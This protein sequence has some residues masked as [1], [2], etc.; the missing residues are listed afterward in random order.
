VAMQIRIGE[1][2]APHQGR[3]EYPAPVVLGM[4]LFI[5]SEIVFFG[6]L[7][8]AYYTLRG[9]ASVWPP[10]DALA[11]LAPQARLQAIAASL[12][13]WG[14]SVPVHL[15]VL[16]MR[17]RDGAAMRG[18]LLLTIGMG[19]VFMGW[20]VSEWASSPFSVSAHAYGTIFFALTG[21]HALH[22]LI[23]LILLS[24]VVARI[25]Q[26][27]YREGDQSGPEAV[28]YYWHFVDAVWVGVFATIYLV[29]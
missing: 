21:F 20:K 28:A 8:A 12:V 24:G 7:F 3:L 10:P 15:A 13:L 22:L 4:V 26:G 25:A 2:R 9:G 18:W 17:R 14:S 16:S 27:A 23:G 5:A 29:R 1:T 6:S 11:A 19:I